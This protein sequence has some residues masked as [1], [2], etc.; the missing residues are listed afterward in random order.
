MLH[1]VGRLLGYYFYSLHFLVISELSGDNRYRESLPQ[2]VPYTF[3]Q[4]GEARPLSTTHL[5]HGCG[6]LVHHRIDCVLVA[7]ARGSFVEAASRAHMDSRSPL[8][9]LF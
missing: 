6:D 3:W 8:H 2:S 9:I 4:A 5:M 1:L 7:H